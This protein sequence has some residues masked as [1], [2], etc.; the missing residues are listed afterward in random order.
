M[1]REA[2]GEVLA[3]RYSARFVNIFNEPVGN[4]ARLLD[5]RAVSKKLLP[6]EIAVISSNNSILNL[7]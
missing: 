4:S 2:K 7:D 5:Q 3:P 1:A 6:T